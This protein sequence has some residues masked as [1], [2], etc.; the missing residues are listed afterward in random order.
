MVACSIKSC[1]N[2]SENVKGKKIKFHS[3]PK[4]PEFILKWMKACGKEV[5]L[6][7]GKYINLTLLYIK[8]LIDN[9]FLM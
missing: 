1:K 5:N 4:D 8:I 6:K 7:T 3:F 2:R 9:I